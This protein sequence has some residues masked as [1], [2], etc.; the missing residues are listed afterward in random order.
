MTL[1]AH[2]CEGV[3]VHSSLVMLLEFIEFPQHFDVVEFQTLADHWN[4]LSLSFFSHSV[5]A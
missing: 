5:V 4:S 1:S 3:L 2:H